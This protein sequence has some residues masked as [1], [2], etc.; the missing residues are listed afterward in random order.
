MTTILADTINLGLTKMAESCLGT[1]Y[2]RLSWLQAWQTRDE[3]YGAA[4]AELVNAQL[5]QPFALLWGDGATSSSDGQ[6]FKAGR[7]S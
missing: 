6:R 1:S 7:E 4:L 5:R 3:T 2:A